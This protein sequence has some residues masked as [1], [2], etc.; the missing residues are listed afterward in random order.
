MSKQ[1]PTVEV[2]VISDVMCPWCYIGKKNLESAA[3]QLG[4]IAIDVSWRPYQLDP[5]IP[6]GGKDRKEYLDAKFGG[7]EKAREIYKRVEDAGSAAGI[8]FRFDAIKVAPN[9]LDAHRV[10][11][12]AGGVSNEV[13]DRLVN[14]LFALY[15]EQGGNVGD[16]EIL[17]SAAGECGM[18]EQLVRDLL[19][20]DQDKDAVIAEIGLA[21]QMGVTGVPCFIVGKK[22]A[23]MGAQPASTLVQAIRQVQA[24]RAEEEQFGTGQG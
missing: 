10:I 21:Q 9:T 8:G 4:E 17:V 22:Y 13:Q 14:R 12:W 19:A 11:R 18:D 7:P 2:D 24:E 15:F 6:P 5:T 1:A 3:S 23:V 20:S 16:T